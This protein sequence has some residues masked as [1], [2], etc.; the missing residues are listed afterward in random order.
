M[1]LFGA[2]SP[3][4]F[5]NSEDGLTRQRAAETLK[6]SYHHELYAF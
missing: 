1:V 2:Y 3:P 6:V 4:T 5:R